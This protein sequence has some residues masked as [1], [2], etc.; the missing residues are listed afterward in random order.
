[1][2]GAD[3]RILFTYRLLVQAGYRDDGIAAEE[4][5]EKREAHRR[6]AV[7]DDLCIGCYACRGVCPVSAIRIWDGEAHIT[8]SLGCVDCADPPCVPA[9]PTSALEDRGVGRARLP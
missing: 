1:M 2:A 6:I 5:T 7:R 3:L 9:C 4:P 8:N